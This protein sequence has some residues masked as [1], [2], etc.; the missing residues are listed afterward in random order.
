KNVGQKYR[1]GISPYYLSLIDDDNKFDPVKLQSIPTKFEL[2]NEGDSDPMSE[3]FTNPAGVITRRYPDRL[4]INVTNICAMYCRHCQRRRNIG[5]SDHHNSKEDLI[6]SIEYIKANPEIRDVLITGGD[7]LAL[8]DD[9]LDWLLVG[10]YK[11]STV[12]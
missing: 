12:D 2:T 7:A 11:I 9:M 5:S 8:S 4:I 10:L 1:W 6:D 3:E